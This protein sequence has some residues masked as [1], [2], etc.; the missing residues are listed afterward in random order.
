LAKERDDLTLIGCRAYASRGVHE[1]LSESKLA[2]WFARQIGPLYAVEKELRE[3]K[4]GPQEAI[5]PRAP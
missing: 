5:S 3:K 2:A 4:T 1:A